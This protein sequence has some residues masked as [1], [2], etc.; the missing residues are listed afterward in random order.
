MEK[1]LYRPTFED[2]ID[3]VDANQEY[4]SEGK[5]ID[6]HPWWRAGLPNDSGT[7]S[8]LQSR[9]YEM[10]LAPALMTARYFRIL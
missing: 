8:G 1:N 5:G 9:E 2:N 6:S 10:T 3:H 4:G 7:G